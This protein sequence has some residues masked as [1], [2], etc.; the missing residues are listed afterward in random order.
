MRASLEGVSGPR[1]RWSLTRGGV[2]PSSE[3]E[4]CGCGVVCVLLFAKEN[5]FSPGF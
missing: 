4:F 2:Q 1:A 3:A 5:G